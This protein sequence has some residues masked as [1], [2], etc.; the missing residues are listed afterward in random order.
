[1]KISKKPQPTNETKS[2]FVDRDVQRYGFQKHLTAI[3]NSGVGDGLLLIYSGVGGIGKTLLFDQFKEMAG[4]SKKNFVLHDFKSN[5]DMLAV[6]KALRKNLNDRYRMEFP[7]FDKGCIYLA[8]KN[9]EFVSNEQKKKILMDTAAFRWFKRNLFI[10]L[11]GL[12]LKNCSDYVTFVDKLTDKVSDTIGESAA[13]DLKNFLLDAVDASAYLKS[14]TASFA[15]CVQKIFSGS[16]E[17]FVLVKA[18][19][20]VLNFLESRIQKADEKERAN[21][22]EFYGEI[23]IELEDR[24]V[25]DDPAYIKELLPQ[26]FAQDLSYWLNYTDTDLIVF[27]DTYEVLTGEELGR[28]KSVRLISENRDVPVD[29]WIGEL[30]AAERVMWVIASRYEITEIGEVLLKD[31]DAVEKY[32]VDVL[33]KNWANEYLKRLKVNDENLRKGIIELTGGHPLY[34]A[35]CSVTYHNIINAKKV[36]RMSDFGKN[37]DKIIERALGSF[38]D[39]TRFLLQKLCILGKWTDELASAAISDSNPNTYKRLTDLFAEEYEPDLDDD[40]F[41]IYNFNR[42]ISAFMLPGLKQDVLFSPVFAGIRD[43]ANEFFKKFFA[44]N[45][46]E[47]YELDGKPE[48][49]FGMWSDIILRTT[50]KPEELMTLY[51]ENLAPLEEYFDLS[52]QANCA[53]KFLTKIGDTETFPSAY[54]QHCLGATKFFQYRIE[55]ALELER[56]AYSKVQRLPL[57]DET[58]PL[59]LVVTNCLA[60]ILRRLERWADEINLREEIVAECEIYYPD[61]DDERTLDA[62]ENLARALEYDGRIDEAIEIRR[63]IVE[64]LDGRDDEIFILAAKNL[65]AAL[66]KGNRYEDAISVRKI[67][68]DVCE[69]IQDDEKI[70]DALWRLAWAWD[71]ISDQKAVEEKLACYQK[72]FRI[73][74]KND[75]A[76]QFDL[77]V[78]IKDALEMLDRQD[79]AAQIYKN[80]ID[81]LK[82]RLEAC[83]EINEET[84]KLMASLSDMLGDLFNKD[85]DYNES[86]RWREKAT[87]ALNVIVEQICREPVK[88]YSAAIS[89]L[90]GYSDFLNDQL[91]HEWQVMLWRKILALTEK[92]PAA[93]DKE[94]FDAKKKLTNHLRNLIERRA[95][96]EYFAEELRLFEEIETHYKKIFPQ[97]FDEFSDIDLLHQGHLLSIHFDDLPAAVA[98]RMEILDFVEK[99]P[100]ATAK[101]IFDAMGKIAETFNHAKK[102]SDEAEW[103]ERKLDFCHEHFTEDAPEILSTLRNLSSVYKTLKDYDKAEHYQKILVDLTEKKHG[104]EHS[105]TLEEKERLARILHEAGKLDEEADLRKQ[106]D[107]APPLLEDLDSEFDEILAAMG[108][109]FETDSLEEASLK[110]QD[111]AERLTRWLNTVD[112]ALK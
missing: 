47:Y 34:L 45:Q 32:T 43:G 76:I 49:Y 102:Y 73:H 81:K 50:D 51:R 6:L 109:L 12:V 55:E 36:P 59:K 84:F 65:A 62:K 41:V 20:P 66:E 82:R 52:T 72:I 39:P 89:T 106:I 79:E 48:I 57:D 33:E 83:D 13:E 60:D 74:E 100:K 27:L 87:E 22:N 30:L 68:L 54:F 10:A 16:V 35:A 1:M 112:K 88:D 44:E 96:D 40:E 24:N 46:Q 69:D 71:G 93:T 26:L 63:K 2:N 92:N 95:K 53:E 7:L 91:H 56:A 14:S 21:G 4:E 77:F 23:L 86:E 90:K 11:N 19:K 101:H 70:I 28:K 61:A 58:R 15:E 75:M 3:K 108:E 107:E 17:F 110:A 80:S 38:D 25:E 104:A 111:S 99:H 29:W 31:I 9:G 37:G 98:K 78:A 105:D 103:H 85:A 64:T 42:T 67:I 8:Q 97:N 5:T 18:L 94:I